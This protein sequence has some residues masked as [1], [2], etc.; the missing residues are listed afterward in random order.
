MT[1]IR[2]RCCVPFCQ[3]TRGPRK[4]DTQPLHEDMQWICAAHWRPVP[5]RMRQ[6]LS[7]ARN[8]FGG[9]PYRRKGSPKL[10]RNRRAY[11]RL[12][13]RCKRAAIERAMGI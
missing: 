2:L 12:W 7:R 8:W 5:K 9:E 13:E 11:W 4:G 10:R 6:A 3:H 1:T